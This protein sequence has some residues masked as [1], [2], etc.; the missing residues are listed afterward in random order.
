MS[1]PIKNT[2]S[3]PKL[4]WKVARKVVTCMFTSNT[5]LC[6]APDSIHLAV[7]S[8][9]GTLRIIDLDREQYS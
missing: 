9:D 4:F 7:T 5:A 1:K 3:N 6:F 2:K 8:M